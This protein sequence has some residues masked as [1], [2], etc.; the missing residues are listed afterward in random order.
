MPNSF[1]LV[2]GFF[3]VPCLD[4]EGTGDRTSGWISPLSEQTRTSN[5]LQMSLQRQ[6]ILL[7]YLKALSI[8]PVWG[9]NPIPPARQSG[10]LPTEPNGRWC[11]YDCRVGN[12]L[13]RTVPDIPEKKKKRKIYDQATK[14]FHIT[15]FLGCFSNV[16]INFASN[17]VQ[18]LSS[19]QPRNR[20][21]ETE[22]TAW[23]QTSLLFKSFFDRRNIEP[24]LS[25]PPP[26]VPDFLISQFSFSIHRFPFLSSVFT[27]F[28]HWRSLRGGERLW[29][30]SSL[31]FVQRYNFTGHSARRE[32]KRPTKEAMGD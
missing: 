32:K 23:L 9:S 8:G 31:F 27:P 14:F 30:A 22:K 3:N 10:T 4:I 5:H 20:A 26:H 19:P 17:R 12:A 21:H 25:H 29:I 28:R 2:C 24:S 13:A 7:S 16:K 6:H 18:S 1:R 11:N 15:T